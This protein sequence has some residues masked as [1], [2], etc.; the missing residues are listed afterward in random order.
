MLSI[1]WRWFNFYCCL[2]IALATHIKLCKLCVLNIIWASKEKLGGTGKMK[3][4]FQNQFF[5]S[6]MSDPDTIVQNVPLR[7]HWHSQEQWGRSG[8]QTLEKPGARTFSLVHSQLGNNDPL[9]YKILY[10]LFLKCCFEGRLVWEKN[11]I[12][13][14][15]KEIQDASLMK[16]GSNILV[17]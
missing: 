17:G 8:C 13:P 4:N 12:S 14:C 11:N 6:K 1:P 5:F 15:C 7:F 3:K 2:L 10:S 16:K 9:K